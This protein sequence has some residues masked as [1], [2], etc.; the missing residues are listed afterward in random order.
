MN[1][2]NYC[3]LEECSALAKDEY[4]QLHQERRV[5]KHFRIVEKTVSVPWCNK[6][7]RAILGI[8]GS[9]YCKHCKDREDITINLPRTWWGRE[10]AESEGL[11]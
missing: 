6:K 9:F 7:D 4:C 8:D 5:C 1:D 11:E 2:W 10:K 3:N